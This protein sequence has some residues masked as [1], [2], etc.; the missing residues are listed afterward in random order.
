M[1]FNLGIINE[2]KEKKGV[3]ILIGD[4]IKNY[5][6]VPNNILDNIQ[7]NFAFFYERREREYGLN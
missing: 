2:T 6:L 7:L 4:Y 5:I 3:L 1:M